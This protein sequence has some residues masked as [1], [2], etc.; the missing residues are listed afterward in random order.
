MCPIVIPAKAGIHV[1]HRHSRESGNPRAPS[2][3][4]RKRESTLSISKCDHSWKLVGSKWIPAFAGM[5]T[6]VQ[7]T[8]LY[9]FSLE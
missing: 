8:I 7:M 3:F 9:V 5:T 4:P 2:S 6:S 1:P